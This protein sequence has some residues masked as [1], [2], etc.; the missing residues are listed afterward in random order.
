MFANAGRQCDN[1]NWQER[2]QVRTMSKNKKIEIEKRKYYE[3][4]NRY[5]FT[6]DCE[7]TCIMYD[8]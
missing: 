4:C 3:D 2:T 8:S 6:Y 7:R 5:T 1:K